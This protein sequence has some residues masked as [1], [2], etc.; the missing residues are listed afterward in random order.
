MNLF[1]LVR[2]FVVIEISCLLPVL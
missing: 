1:H 2:L